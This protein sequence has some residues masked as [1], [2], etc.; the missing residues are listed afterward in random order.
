MQKSV[1]EYLERTVGSYP[2]KVAVQDSEIS[3]TFSELWAAAKRISN[4]IKAKDITKNS[5][6]GVFI[7]K[8]CKMVESFAGIKKRC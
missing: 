4:A 7:P 3:V 2:N 5:P 8:G 6:I 1:I